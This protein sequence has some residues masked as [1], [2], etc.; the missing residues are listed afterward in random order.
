[1]E[2]SE[3]GCGQGRVVDWH[4]GTGGQ[5]RGNW[6]EGAGASQSIFKMIVDRGWRCGGGVA[7]YFSKL[8]RAEDEVQEST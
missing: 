3:S 7:R 6:D 5:G 2:A 4:E 8:D 1:M